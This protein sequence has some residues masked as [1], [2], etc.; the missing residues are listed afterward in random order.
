MLM[1]DRR[2]PSL[3]ALRAFEAV[4]R[5]GSFTRAA[6][7]LGVT[8]SGASHHI[9]L[10]EADLGVRLLERDRRGL[11]LTAAGED[12]FGAATHAFALLKSSIGRVAKPP[13]GMKLTVST[14]FTFAAKWLL[15]SLPD[16]QA[17]HPDVALRVDASD[18]L[19]DLVGGATDLAIRYGLGDYAGLH[20]VPL[21]SE[22]LFPVCAPGLADA[23]KSTD[24]LAQAVLLTDPGVNLFRT[25]PDWEEWFA[26][27]AGKGLKPARM[28]EMSSYL[29]VYE[30]ALDGRGVALGRGPLVARDLAAGRLVRPLAAETRSE[31]G[32]WAVCARNRVAEP[33]I[34]AFMEWLKVAWA[35]S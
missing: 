23:I 19:A 17:A 24:D 20:V 29:L 5:H 1:R 22:S 4:A 15:P 35:S 8:Q 21:G 31:R 7:E 6:A 30:A 28:L 3:T 33:A 25:G 10:L 9:A 11:R 18:D 34:A 13:H 32:Y 12:L 2:L 14:F 16:F 26:R 27:A